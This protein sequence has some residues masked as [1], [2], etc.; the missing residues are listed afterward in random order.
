[1]DRWFFFIE[2][3]NLATCLIC[4]FQTANIKKSNISRHYDTNHAASLS[5]LSPS[6]KKLKLDDFLKKPPTLH[7]FA[8]KTAKNKYKYKKASMHVAYIQGK[9]C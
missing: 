5:A 6:E 1:M 9:K 7:D 8:G 2:D 4:D 3:S